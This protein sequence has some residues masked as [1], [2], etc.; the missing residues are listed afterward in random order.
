LLN[1]DKDFHAMTQEKELSISSVS[2]LRTILLIAGTIIGYLSF[3][4]SQPAV[5]YSMLTV[6]L[7]LSVYGCYLW[8]KL[9]GHHWMW[10]IFGLLAPA[11]FFMLAILPDR[12]K[13]PPD[14]TG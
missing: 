7:C 6:A 14:I 2:R 8:A 5:A 10:M 12:S 13:K 1:N 4:P 9:K 3:L 11:G